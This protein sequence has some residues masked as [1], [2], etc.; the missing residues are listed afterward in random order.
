MDFIVWVVVA[1]ALA[2]AEIL[3]SGFYLLFFAFGAAI[4]AIAAIFVPELNS[5][6]WIFLLSSVFFLLL[7]RPF[8]KRVFNLTDQPSHPS[9]ASAL[10]GEVVLVL[11]AVDRYGGRVRVLHSGEVWS[12]YIKPEAGEAP[13][14]LPEGAEGVVSAVDGAKLVIQPRPA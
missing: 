8:L 11:E 12:A 5:Q 2:I 3:I 10:I 7:G 4:T 13:S 9:N 14:G 1:V 6:L